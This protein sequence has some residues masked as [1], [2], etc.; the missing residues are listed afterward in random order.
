[1][2]AGLSG[3]FK[4]TM[5]AHFLLGGGPDAPPALWLTFQEG[6]ADLE[7]RFG[8]R[9][10]NFQGGS[11]KDRL[12]VLEAI[13]G[14]EPVEKLLSLVEEGILEHGVDL[15]AID[16]LNDLVSSMPDDEARFEAADWFLRRLR[17]LRVTV[18]VTQRLTRVTGRNPLSEI[19]WAQLADTIVYLGLVEI[20]SRLEK[21]VSV[22]KHRGGA[23]PGDLRAIV[24]DDTGLRIHDRFVG[25][26]GVLQGT[27][28]GRRK[29]RIE[30]IFQP[31]YFIRDFLTLARE[32]QI[33]EEQRSA[34]LANVAGETTRLIELLGLYFDQPTPD[35]AERAKD[36]TS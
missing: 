29:A 25:M 18:L 2:V 11:T 36:K 32:Q 14:R 22:L 35:G 4:T 13:P 5:A 3:T 30:E 26:S 17:A 9:G 16:S 6:A 19:A 20:E 28:L 8:G 33:G 27:P 34:A 23:V 24:R 12:T 1:M 31:L 15:V 7:L 21:V 10:L